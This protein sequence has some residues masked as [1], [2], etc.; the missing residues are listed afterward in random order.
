MLMPLMLKQPPADPVAAKGLTQADIDRLRDKVEAYIDELV[1]ALRTSAP[2]IPPEVLRKTL[3]KG[4]CLCKAASRL[5]MEP[6][7]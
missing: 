7:T 3:M 6:Q 5:L 4:E 1:T 2:G